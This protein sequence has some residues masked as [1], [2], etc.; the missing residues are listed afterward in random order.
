MIARIL[1]VVF[2][3]I[4]LL[5]GC[6]SNTSLLPLSANDPANPNAPEPAFSPR[7][8]LLQSNMS[9]ITEQPTTTLTPPTKLPVPTPSGYTCPMHPDVVQSGP[10]ICP[11]CGMK[12]VPK[13]QLKTN[14]DDK[15]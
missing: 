7:S 9:E 13:D 15:Q 4:L 12:L 2:C 1:N 10:G 8:D 5:T 11:L 3:S 6:A 14:V